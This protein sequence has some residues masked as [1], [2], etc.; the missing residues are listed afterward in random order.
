MHLLV[1]PEDCNDLAGIGR[2]LNTPAYENISPSFLVRARSLVAKQMRDEVL[3]V[4]LEEYA[5]ETARLKAS[6][7]E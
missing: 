1:S 7:T 4:F 5:A 2:I 3:A 6:T